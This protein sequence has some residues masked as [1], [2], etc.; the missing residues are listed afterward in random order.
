MWREFPKV[1]GFK[2][3]LNFTGCLAVL[4][5]T[6]LVSIDTWDPRE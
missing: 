5:L 6:V 3:S 4:L 2:A 1:K